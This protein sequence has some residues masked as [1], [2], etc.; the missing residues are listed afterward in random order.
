MFI[1][2]KNYSAD[3][4][5]LRLRVALED[6]GIDAFVDKMDVP[7]KYQATEKWWEYRDQAI[8]DCDTFVMLVTVGFGNSPQIIREIQLAGDKH[9]DMMCFR[10]SRM[11]PELMINLGD[12]ILNTKD[13]QQIEFS[14]GAE[15]VRQFFDYYERQST[16]KPKSNT[17]TTPPIHATVKKSH[18]LPAV[19]FEIT[20]SVANTQVQRILPDV[21]F[22]IRNW[23]DT[24][25]KAWVKVK[26]LLGGKDL[27]L[28][29]GVTRGKQYLGYYDGKTAWNLNPYHAIFGHFSLPKEC[30]NSPENLTLVVSASFEN[31]HRGKFDYLPVAW[32]YM[33][34]TNSWYI[35]PA[36]L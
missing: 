15:L 6:N 29:E 2:Y 16:V 35:E 21:G 9:K 33:K 17:S 27:G 32:T 8:C 25:L 13:I 36:G 26:V 4:L 3:D 5:A 20:Q 11:K 7:T 22:N 23:S 18:A 1:C 12:K 28:I 31:Q 34:K 14:T 24:C 19:N 30:V 10:W